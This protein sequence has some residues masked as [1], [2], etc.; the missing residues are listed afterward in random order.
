MLYEVITAVYAQRFDDA[1]VLASVNEVENLATGLSRKIWQ[2][3][4]ILETGT[5]HPGTS[6]T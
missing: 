4:V 1:V 2:K 3:L 6:G 5:R